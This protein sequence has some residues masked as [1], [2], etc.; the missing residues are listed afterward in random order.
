MSQ[1]YGI[2]S[3]PTPSTDTHHERVRFVVVIDAEGGTIARL[4][5][6]SR[7]Q[8]DEFDASVPEVVQMIQGI[9]PVTGA[10]GGEWDVALSG[11]S[12]SERAA[13]KIF[14]LNL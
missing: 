14:T 6:E 13:A 5:R 4:L 10:L 2:E 7:H 11:H 1:T 8:L 12:R 9:V 3:P